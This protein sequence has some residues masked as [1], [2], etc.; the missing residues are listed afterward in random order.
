MPDL[1][2]ELI[3]WERPDHDPVID[4]RDAR[5]RRPW[6]RPAARAAVERVADARRSSARAR[7]CHRGARSTPR[8]RLLLAAVGG[9]ATRPRATRSA[10]ASSTAGPRS[11][12]VAPPDATDA[13]RATRRRREPAP[14]APSATLP[15]SRP[16]RRPEAGQRRPPR[17]RPHR[18]HRLADDAAGAGRRRAGLVP[19]LEQRLAAGRARRRSWRR[20]AEALRWDAGR[21]SFGDAPRDFDGLVGDWEAQVDLTWIVGLLLRGWRKG[22]DAEAGA[23]LASGASA[24]DDLAWWCRAAL[25]A[26]ERRL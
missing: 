6:D 2:T 23:T 8:L 15:G 9:V 12:G 3:A 24:R 19:R 14:R 21:W 17:R 4:A 5:P 18:L 22:L 11:G 13:H 1:S 26:A 25:D 20:Y 7:R 16:A 10:S